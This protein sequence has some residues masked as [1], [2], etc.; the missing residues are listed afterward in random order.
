M[1]VVAIMKMVMIGGRSVVGTEAKIIRGA[2]CAAHVDH[3]DVNISICVSTVIMIIQFNSLTP[4]NISSLSS[5]FSLPP[6]L[7]QLE[8]VIALS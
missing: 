2:E 6:L 3:A 5:M 1:V 7:S 8:N 4:S